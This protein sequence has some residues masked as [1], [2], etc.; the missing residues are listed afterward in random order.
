M[1][2]GTEQEGGR[3]REH[4]GE[5]THLGRGG[6]TGLDLQPSWGPPLPGEGSPLTV[7]V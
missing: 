3:E 7:R 5:V 1:W 6:R 2:L 4:E